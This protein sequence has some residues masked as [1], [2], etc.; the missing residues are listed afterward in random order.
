MIY[1]LND[2]NEKAELDFC[3]SYSAVYRDNILYA[4]L[5][6]IRHFISAGCYDNDHWYLGTNLRGI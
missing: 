2:I 3:K 5:Q 6:Y 1:I 4:T